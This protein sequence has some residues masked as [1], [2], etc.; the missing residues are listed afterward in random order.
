[1]SSDYVRTYD[2]S[3]HAQ[4]PDN[5]A[6]SPDS[7]L[8][9]ASSETNQTDETTAQKPLSPDR[10]NPYDAEANPSQL[11]EGNRADGAAAVV[12]ANQTTET[13]TK[14]PRSRKVW[15]WSIL[16]VLLV[17]GGFVGWRAFGNRQPAAAQAPPPMPVK[18]QTVTSGQVQSTAEF[19]GKLEAQ[20]RVSLQP[21]IQ[22]RVDRVLV[23]SG[24]RVRQG[25]PIL[26]LSL[27]QT[28]ANVSSAIATVNSNRAAVT[29]AEAQLEAKRADRAKAAS[30]VKL[31]EVQF[32]RTQYLV[33]QGAQA[34]SELDTARNKLETAIAT[35]NAA[36]KDVNASQ[37]SVNQA[38]S[39]VDQAQAQVAA[40]EVNLNQKQIVAPIDGIV[41]D[42][43]IK[44]GDYVSVGQ[45]LTSIIKNESLDMR[46]SVPSNN[47]AQLRQGLPVE[48]LDAETG[49]QLTRGSISFISPQIDADAQSILIKARF[50]NADGKLRD[51]QY[52]RARIIWN[53][54]AG[55]LIPTDAVNRVGGQSFV[56]VVQEDRS[57]EKPQFVVHQKPVKL[58]DVQNDRYPILDGVKAG[59]RI[60]TSNILKLRDG[61]PIQPD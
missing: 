11:Q 19:V 48:L 28:Q 49:K 25:T 44:A 50:N 12:D 2:A 35:L 20:Q 38:Q 60:A 22:G 7:V 10:T 16:T 15:L 40:N 9:S 57:K 1:M 56:Y 24:A 17:G 5:T 54:K 45:T 14:Q 37:A 27:D 42:F 4:E 6:N 58:G 21:Q 61:A 13:T 51:G 53:Q 47:V 36:D 3:G 43:A 41:G 29:T 46:I 30:D 52:V 8:A 59:D 18:V 32:K 31:Q 26:T 39:N 55:I 33:G 34:Q 23:A